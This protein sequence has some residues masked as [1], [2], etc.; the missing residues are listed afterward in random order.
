M[1]APGLLIF[2]PAVAYHFHLNLPEKFTNL[3]PTFKPVHV[4]LTFRGTYHL[5]ANKPDF[6]QHK[7]SKNTNAIGMRGRNVCNFFI[8]F[9]FAMWI[10]YTFE[11][12]NVNSSI[13]EAEVLG[14][15]VWAIIQRMTLPMIIFFRFHALVFCVELRKQYTGTETKEN[16]ARSAS[17]P[18]MVS[19]I[20]WRLKHPNIRHSD[21]NSTGNEDNPTEN[22][23][24]R[25]PE[26]QSS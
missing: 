8:F 2:D 26:P 1:W 22:Q 19:N 7:S 20:L 23:D 12:Q 5:A 6:F 18:S 11:R 25:F 17:S 4:F 10:I 15:V 21:T 3:R 16:T 14:T 9:N 13:I 24:P